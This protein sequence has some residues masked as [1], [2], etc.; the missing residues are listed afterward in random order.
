[1]LIEYKE[2]QEKLKDE[3]THILEAMLKCSLG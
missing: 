2:F 1:M 3:E